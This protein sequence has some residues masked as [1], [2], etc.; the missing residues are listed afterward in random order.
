ML[1]DPIQIVAQVARV[2]EEIG[3]PYLVGGSLASSRYGLPRTTQDVD[4][5][6]D[7]REEQVGSLIRAL[8][9]EFYIDAGMI[10]EAIRHRSSFN[11]IHLQA[12]YK[13][14]LFLLKADTWAQREMARRRAERIGP[15]G[16]IT[17]YFCSP[18]DIILHK[19]DWYRLG[20]GV[21]DRQWNDVLGVLKVQA[22]EL[23]TAYLRQWASE[24]GLTDLLERALREAG[25]TL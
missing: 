7:L 20:G 2:L 22:S 9:D 12:A 24:L 14:D 4:L 11:V 23:E 15:E 5:V 25:V 19:L 13:V 10:R 21:S 6:V 3:I 17:L 18:E 16:L 1:P 8:R